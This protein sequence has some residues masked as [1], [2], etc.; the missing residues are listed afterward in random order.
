M[1]W[2]GIGALLASVSYLLYHH[3]PTTWSC[4]L[5]FCNSAVNHRQTVPRLEHPEVS[6]EIEIHSDVHT[7]EGSLDSTTQS[8][9]TTPKVNPTLAFSEIPDIKLDS[10]SFLPKNEEKPTYTA[11]TSPSIETTVVSVTP[12]ASSS[13]SVSQQPCPPKPPPP[14]TTNAATLP[15]SAITKPAG[16]M[17]PPPRPSPNTPL[18]T[19]PSAA[20]SLRVPPQP[21]ISTSSLAPPPKPGQSRLTSSTL[22]PLPVPGQPQRPSR[23]V[24]LEPGHSPLDWAALTADPRNNLRGANLPPGLI[25]VPPSM[26][27]SFNGRKG[28]DSWTSY[29]GRVYNITPYLPFHPGGKGELMRGAGKDSE[30]LFA[31]IHPWVNWDGMLSECLVGILVKEHDTGSIR[32]PGNLDEMD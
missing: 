9:E 12:P 17:P 21:R 27:K 16:L 29:Q 22:S 1:G 6:N 32:E 14:T 13:V 19:P 28:R 24:I 2:V 4:V 30:Q 11:S 8:T 3:P 20:A 26:L 31:E 25:R 15:S 7:I 18:R 5:W 10:P 23:Q